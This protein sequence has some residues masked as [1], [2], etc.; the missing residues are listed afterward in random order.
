MYH[1]SS[2]SGRRDAGQ[3]F[4]PG[5]SYGS[6]AP[7][8]WE[9]PSD[10]DSD[11]D[12]DSHTSDDVSYGP[13]S[14]SSEGINMFDTLRGE[15]RGGHHR[16]GRGRDPG[17]A[18]GRNPRSGGGRGSMMGGGMSGLHGGTG[19]HGG[20]RGPRPGGGRDP[21]AGSGLRSDDG[22][23]GHHGGRRGHRGGMSGRRD[24]MD[25]HRGGMGGHRGGMQGSSLTPDE[26]GDS[27][28]E[29]RLGGRFGSHPGYGLPQPWWPPQG[30]TGAHLPNTLP[31]RDLRYYYYGGA[32][33]GQD[34]GAYG[35]G[36]GEGYGGGYGGGYG[37]GYG[38]G[39]RRGYRGED[40]YDS[41]DS[42]DSEDFYQ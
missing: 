17:V 29:D 41:S 15:R 26:E 12:S 22:M 14:E 6:Y 42:S 35:E 20:G 37:E 24:G 7:Y 38:G 30:N 11:S 10:S 23:S 9:L 5:E 39:L 31:G 2:R 21:I 3:F 8:D 28:G 1:P 13:G 32:S 34:G 25:G 36:Y 16:G 27:A 18:D 4:G 19:R 40:L 33:R